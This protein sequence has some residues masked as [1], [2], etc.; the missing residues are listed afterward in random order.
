M[1]ASKAGLQDLGSSRGTEKHIYNNLAVNAHENEIVENSSESSTKN[2]SDTVEVVAKILM[3][4][5]Y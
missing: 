2:A 4:C 3:F 1:D 5:S